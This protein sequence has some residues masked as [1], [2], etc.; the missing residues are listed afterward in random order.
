MSRDVPEWW[1][2]DDNEAVPM[3]VQVRVFGRYEGHCGDC[4]RLIGAGDGPRIDH[5][6]ALINGGENRERNLQLLCAACHAYKTKEDLDEKSK[7]YRIRQR[8]LGLKPKRR[9]RWG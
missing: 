9:W 3:R 8:H 7:V 2:R 1:G 5:I 4:G 6:R